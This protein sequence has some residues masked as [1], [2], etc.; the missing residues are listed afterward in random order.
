VYDVAP[1]IVRSGD[2]IPV[3]VYVFNLTAKDRVFL[4]FRALPV[5]VRDGRG[6]IIPIHPEYQ[7]VNTGFKGG[8]GFSGP[9]IRMPAGQ[10]T[11][12]TVNLRKFYDLGKP[13]VYWVQVGHPTG[14]P[15]SFSPVAWPLPRPIWILPPNATR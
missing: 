5:R 11:R 10:V 14:G 12:Q 7:W 1:L 6:R 15:A 4:N 8:W 2:A 9:S 3:T 13:G